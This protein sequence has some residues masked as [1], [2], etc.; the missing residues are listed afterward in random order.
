[1]LSKFS[2]HYCLK[3]ISNNSFHWSTEYFFMGLFFS[4][5][6]LGSDGQIKYPRSWKEWI[7]QVLY[8][9]INIFH[10]FT[11]LIDSYNWNL[12]SNFFMPSTPL[13]DGNLES[14]LSSSAPV[15]GAG[16]RTQRQERGT[17]KEKEI[18]QIWLCYFIV[19]PK[20]GA[21]RAHRC[22][23]P[24]TT[25]EVCK[26]CLE[27]GKLTSEIQDSLES[28]ISLVKNKFSLAFKKCYMLNAL[29]AGSNYSPKETAQHIKMHM[30]CRSKIENFSFPIKPTPLFL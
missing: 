25:D 19:L 22:P 14:P 28:M 21:G 7:Y 5:D 23:T 8:S 30:F 17:E 10:A 16:E 18:R 13:G 6:N 1:M 15:G 24:T 9:F 12:G 29:V 4:G 11:Y 26:S 20:A 27:K 3:S 2:F